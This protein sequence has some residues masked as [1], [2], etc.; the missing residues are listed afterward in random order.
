MRL[1]KEFGLK[2]Q[3]DNEKKIGK[4]PEKRE[5]PCEIQSVIPFKVHWLAV[6]K[7]F[8]E[9]VEIWTCCAEFFFFFFVKFTLIYRWRLFQI[10]ESVMKLSGEEMTKLFLPIKLS[11]QIMTLYSFRRKGNDFLQDFGFLERL[12]IGFLENLQIFGSYQSFP[13]QSTS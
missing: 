3:E 1:L 2:V 10:V 13:N 12:Q 11:I 6:P 8:R 5:K 4:L 9:V 7:K